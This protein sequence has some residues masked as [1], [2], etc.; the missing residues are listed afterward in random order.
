MSPSSSGSSVVPSPAAVAERP[1]ATARR[2]STPARV[3][4]PREPAATP[5]LLWRGVL[6]MRI[7]FGVTFLYAGLDKLADPAFLNATGQG[8]IGSQL[9]GFLSVSPLAPLIRAFA[10]PAPVAVG[11]LIAIGEVAV[12][13]GALTGLLFRLSAFGGMVLSLLFWLTASW[14]THPYYYGADLPYAAGWMLLLVAGDGGWTLA[15]GLERFLP[16][17][18]PPRVG[19]VMSR[20]D[21]LRVGLQVAVVGVASTALGAAVW[22]ATGGPTRRPVRLQSGTDGSGTAPGPSPSPTGAAAAPASSTPAGSPGAAATSPATA[23]SHVAFVSDLKAQQALAVT[24]P[25]TGDPAYLFRLASGNVVCYDAIC[26]HQGCPVDFDPGAELFVCPCHGA[27]FDP[28][29]GARVLQGP[30]RQPLV[31]LPL[32]IDPSTGAI[33]IT[34]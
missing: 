31:E 17:P 27:V 33:T 20:R 18:A 12:G 16:A 6:A 32:S 5:A 13:I 8:S 2:R 7:F 34:G 14:A 9:Q 29:K 11:A 25:I 19:E 26:T 1:D 3:R 22:G 15:R 4:E 10:T 30:T 28:A 23:D 24:D 21:A